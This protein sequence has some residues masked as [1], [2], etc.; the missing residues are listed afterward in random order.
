LAGRK[1]RRGSGRDGNNE[2]E[3]NDLV[4]PVH[5]LLATP[6]DNAPTTTVNKQRSDDSLRKR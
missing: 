5:T 1:Q 3:N 4:K 2:G 6:G